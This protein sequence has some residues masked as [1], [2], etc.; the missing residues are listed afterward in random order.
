MMNYREYCKSRS[1]SA[2]WPLDLIKS[3]KQEFEQGLRGESFSSGY[4]NSKIEVLQ[5]FMK[6]F[7]E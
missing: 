2:E 6:M 1:T 4:V 7:D 3:I 5:A